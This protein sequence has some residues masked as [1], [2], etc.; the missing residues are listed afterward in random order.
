ML[1]EDAI[2]SLYDNKQ[3]QYKNDSLGLSV[4][5]P[6]PR[7]DHIIIE[8]KIDDGSI[9]ARTQGSDYS[10]LFSGSV[11]VCQHWPWTQFLNLTVDKTFYKNELDGDITDEVPVEHAFRNIIC[12]IPGP[13]EEFGNDDEE[14]GV[15][16][17]K[18]FNI[19]GGSVVDGGGAN[20]GNNS[21]H[22]GWSSTFAQSISKVDDANDVSDAVDEG[23]DELCR[24]TTS[25]HMTYD[26]Y[27]QS[28]YSNIQ[29]KN[30]NVGDFPSP[31]Q[32][33]Q[34]PQLPQQITSDTVP[35]SSV[36]SEGLTVD[37]AD[38]A[39]EESI[40]EP[41]T[42]NHKYELKFQNN[43]L[44]MDFMDHPFDEKD[45]SMNEDISNTSLNRLREQTSEA[46]RRTLTDGFTLFT[47]LQLL[48]DSQKNQTPS[49]SK[50]TDHDQRSSPTKSL[51]K[52]AEALGQTAL[53][54]SSEVLLQ[55]EQKRREERKT[56]R[57]NFSAVDVEEPIKLFGT[58]QVLSTEARKK[59]ENETEEELIR[60]RVV[61]SKLQR[62]A[63]R[64]VTA[65][66][67]SRKR[68]EAIKAQLAAVEEAAAVEG[69]ETSW[70]TWSGWL[71]DEVVS[72]HLLE[73]VLQM[74]PLLPRPVGGFES[75]LFPGV[76]ACRRCPQSKKVKIESAADQFETLSPS[77]GEINLSNEMARD[78]FERQVLYTHYS[79]GN[80]QSNKPFD[81]LFRGHQKSKSSNIRDGY[82][83]VRVPEMSEKFIGLTSADRC[84]YTPVLPPIPATA[85]EVFVDQYG[86][87][88]FYDHA[89]NSFSWGAKGRGKPRFPL[90]SE[91]ED[92]FCPPSTPDPIKA[93]NMSNTQKNTKVEEEE[94]RDALWGEVLKDVKD[95][96]LLSKA[97][98]IDLTNHNLPSVSVH[99]GHDS[100]VLD[101]VTQDMRQTSPHGMNSSAVNSDHSVQENNDIPHKKSQNTLY[102]YPQHKHS[103]QS[104]KSHHD[105]SATSGLD[106]EDLEA[107]ALQYFH[108]HT[109]D[110]GGVAGVTL[111][112]RSSSIA[113]LTP[114]EEAFMMLK[115]LREE[116]SYGENN[117]NMHTRT[118][119]TSLTTEFTNTYANDQ[120]QATVRHFVSSNQLQKCSQGTEKYAWMTLLC[121]ERIRDFR[122]SPMKPKLK[123]LINTNNKTNSPNREAINTSNSEGVRRLL[124][125]SSDDAVIYR[126]EQG[127]NIVTNSTF[128]LDLL[129]PADYEQSFS[130]IDFREYQELVRAVAKSP[131]DL[132]I[133][134]KLAEFL[135][136]TG[137]PLQSVAVLIVASNLTPNV[138]SDTD[139]AL[140]R[141]DSA[142]LHVLTA[143]LCAH[144]LG[145]T[146]PLRFLKRTLPHSI[147]AA[148]P[149][150]S[151]QL[152]Q[153]SVLYTLGDVSEAANLLSNILTRD[154]SCL[155]AMRGLAM[156]RV[157]E[158]Q[159]K[160]A[161]RLLYKLLAAVPADDPTRSEGLYSI[162]RLEIAW[163]QDYFRE[164][165]NIIIETYKAAMS[166][167]RHGRVL[168]FCWAAWGLFVQSQGNAE[169]ALVK[170]VRAVRADDQN[171]AYLA[172]MLKAMASVTAA[173]HGILSGQSAA[174]WKLVGSVGSIDADFRRGLLLF[175]QRGHKWITYLAYAAFCS[176][177]TVTSTTTS[178]YSTTLHI[179]NNNSHNN[180]GNNNNNI[181]N[182]T[183][184]AGSIGIGF[185][186]TG[187]DCQRV[188]E[189]LWAGYDC[190]LAEGRS[191]CWATIA[192]THFYQYSRENYSSAWAVISHQ[193]ANNSNSHFNVKMT[194]ESK[195]YETAALLTVKAYL[196]FDMGSI[197]TAVNLATAALTTFPSLP[198]AQ[199]LLAIDMWM[200]GHRQRALAVMLQ[201]SDFSDTGLG[202]IRKSITESVFG[203]RSTDTIGQ[204]VRDNP[205]YLRS[206]AVMQATAGDFEGARRHL[207]IANAVAPGNHHGWRMSAILT[208]L[209]GPHGS[210]RVAN[211]D[212][213]DPYIRS[214]ATLAHLDRALAICP[215][216]LESLVLKS[217]VLMELQRF[218]LA[219]PL[220][221]KAVQLAPKNVMSVATLAMCSAAVH[222]NLMS[223]EQSDSERSLTDILR[224]LEPPAEL[225]E[226]ALNLGE[227]S[228]D[229]PLPSEVLYWYG[230]YCLQPESDD[231]EKPN[232]FTCALA[233]SLFLRA[234]HRVDVLPHPPS[235]YMLGWLE[236]T[237]GDLALAEKYYALATQ[238][239]PLPPLAR[240]K[241]RGMARDTVEFLKGQIAVLR[242]KRGKSTRRS[243][244][245]GGGVG[246]KKGN[247]ASRRR[248]TTADQTAVG[249]NDTTRGVSDIR[250]GDATVTADA[251]T[252]FIGES[253]GRFDLPSH[254]SEEECVLE[255]EDISPPEQT[256]QQQ[257]QQHDS[258]Y[259]NVNDHRW[260]DDTLAPA[261]GEKAPLSVAFTS[262][263]EAYP[264]YSSRAARTYTSYMSASLEKDGTD[265]AD[266]GMSS[267]KHSPLTH[268]NMTQSKLSIGR[269]AAVATL[270]KRLQMHQNLVLMV[271]KMG[272]RDE[273]YLMIKENLISSGKFVFIQPFWLEKSFLMFKDCDDWGWLLRGYPAGIDGV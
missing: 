197:E 189:L 69:D 34:L 253:S 119:N 191:T 231:S 126:D 213:R 85:M 29:E 127:Q 165:V 196:A 49:S 269:M 155:E 166:R 137:M 16:W 260:A 123:S 94:A 56:K 194:V 218:K 184:T 112:S 129:S 160:E 236:E 239:H 22:V 43:D 65:S 17:K 153:A 187:G 204:R 182:G 18:P 136:K 264:E 173:A 27:M 262:S 241:L 111:N 144:C 117:L 256:L 140:S 170:Y 172:H 174:M 31:Q 217:Q 250:Y 107:D 207:L 206:L 70:W 87:P 158:G 2:A 266:W 75:K 25:G 81:L 199:R 214:E 74:L 251:G 150:V 272:E 271:D 195:Q 48:L 6:P 221:V 60:T 227:N 162:L 124:S 110:G 248:G 216:D 267:A 7:T 79:D 171:S 23:K 21:I 14:V 178:N 224:S 131:S 180:N 73:A 20:A 64:R 8:S 148:I 102:K 219:L 252:T 51:D 84:L 41:S 42:H 12:G 152:L 133:L 93:R 53:D 179:Y 159:H 120:Q 97:F 35:I 183:T 167:T 157:R 177:M 188:E 82:P 57:K 100:R 128:Q 185:S 40:E 245:S 54:D 259:N 121:Q 77:W 46:A 91:T 50:R 103:K 238:L 30:G 247:G 203:T 67:Q 32:E 36:A 24:R 228:T 5:A 72:R 232:K 10:R 47:R 209:L 59:L 61:I 142:R 62:R 38:I 230:L 205:H 198:S 263:V 106:D 52:L 55:R 212:F 92:K 255:E 122:D 161:L 233:K 11:I 135:L 63:R 99:F 115:P 39:I 86:G 13:D 237:D 116:K 202:F 163:V 211:E 200:R 186:T 210:E 68:L 28:L 105:T 45:P 192:L 226:Q 138:R 78:N 1:D 244:T 181:T 101:P 223:N 208:Y 249:A 261:S 175:G 156:I 164:H 139:L 201:V 95:P 96:A 88:V 234:A 169:D 242:K 89:Q 33:Q 113:S 114:S 145:L 83:S 193:L 273:Q 222:K 215:L 220:L 246:K 235:L 243:G 108:E 257:Q 147:S 66:Q 98:P 9:A 176:S 258:E 132:L 270:K 58:Y 268:H 240:L 265:S 134:L 130:A 15:T 71:R 76:A 229:D 141:L 80:I 125:Q 90:P 190:C 19:M 4:S 151:I 254:I 149:P 109:I 104:L 37:D 143:K 225:F 26:T 146:G 3:W 168:S 118:A 44:N 154:S